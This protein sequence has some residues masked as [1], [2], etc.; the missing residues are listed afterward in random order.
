MSDGN[1]HTGSPLPHVVVGGGAGQIKGNRH[2]M[3]PQGTPQADSCCY[4]CPE[5]RGRAGSSSGSA[6]AIRGRCRVRRRCSSRRSRFLVAGCSVACR[7]R[8]RAAAPRRD[9]AGVDTD[10]EDT[11][12]AARK[13]LGCVYIPHGCIMDR[14][15]PATAGADFEFT[16][17]LKPL[18]PFR[19]SVAVVTNLTRPEQGVDTNHAGAPASWLA[20]VPPKRT[21]GPDYLAR[22]HARSA[23]CEAH[24]AGDDVPVDR[25]GDRGFQRPGRRL[26]AGIQ[27]RVH[28][29]AQLAVGDR[30]AADGDQSAL[31]VRAAVWRR[32]ESG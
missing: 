18:E 21:A 26:R 1:G 27:L 9:G 19:D 29:H 25:A 22:H 3:T 7:R 17:I 16:P 12:A 32:W 20:G 28:E 10:S 30:A 5:V 24:R 14:W 31:G 6:R 23:C 2:I 11:A 4:D 8:A 15:T 13:R